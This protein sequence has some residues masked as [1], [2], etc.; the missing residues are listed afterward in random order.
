M[1]NRTKTIGIVAPARA[2]TTE[3]AEAAKKVAADTFPDGNLS[4][5]FHPQCFMAHNHFA[6]RDED[7]AAAFIE[8][9]N[10]PAIDAIW[11][12]RGGYGSCRFPNDTF[13]ALND[14]AAA[15]TYLGYSDIGAILGFLYKQGIGKIAHGPMIADIT[16][17]G[18]NEAILRALRYLNADSNPSIDQTIDPTQKNIAFN[19]KVLSHIIGTAWQPDFTDHVIALEDIAEYHYQIDRSLFTIT[20]NENIQK[21]RGIKLGRCSDI[22]ENDIDFGYS[23]VEIV[24]YWCEKN[25]IEFLGSAD[26]GHDA[27]NKIVP[28]G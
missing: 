25:S 5:R 11:F 19:I 13:A 6:G 28:F 21:C 26:I 17:Q 4:L 1:E 20:S 9:A 27:D 12:A 15:K 8:Y 3:I 18:G 2:I 24:K 7:R 16:R 14:H 23:D 10:D 22:P